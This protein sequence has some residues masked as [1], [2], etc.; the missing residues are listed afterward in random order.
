MDPDQHVYIGTVSTGPAFKAQISLSQ[1]IEFYRLSLFQTKMVYFFFQ[2][3]G[4]I[5]EI[6]VVALPSKLNTLQ[7]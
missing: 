5:P 1:Y 3:M 2:I 6:N 7:V 4:A